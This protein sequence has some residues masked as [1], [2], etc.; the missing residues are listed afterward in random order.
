LR[1]IFDDPITEWPNLKDQ[2][3]E[4]RNQYPELITVDECVAI[5]NKLAWDNRSTGWG[6]LRKESGNHGS[7]PKTGISCS[8]DWIINKNLELGTDCLV[9]TP[10]STEGPEKDIATPNW[11]EEGDDNFN[12]DNWTEPVEP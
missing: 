7:Q 1:G 6:L 2:L 4:I 11:P 9:S 3:D 5:V 8:V 12:I 10:S